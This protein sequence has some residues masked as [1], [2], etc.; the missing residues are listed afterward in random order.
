METLRKVLFIN[1]IS[2]GVTGL[3]LVFLS[4]TL[5]ELFG[6]VPIAVSETGVFLIAFSIFVFIEARR[7]SL[8]AGRISTIIALDVLWV[9]VSAVIILFQ[10]FNLTAI[11]YIAIGA[12]AIWVT[13]MVYFQSNG[14]KS[15]TRPTV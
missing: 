9:V 8:K 2:S 10:L 6:T 5:G 12:V 7:S 15:M 4:S 11:G 13:G 1:S 14:K 3:G